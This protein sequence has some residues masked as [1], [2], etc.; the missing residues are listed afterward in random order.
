M[1]TK[2]KLSFYDKLF[3][4]NMLRTKRYFCRR[5]QEYS[6]VKQNK[7]VKTVSLEDLVLLYLW[8]YNLYPQNLKKR[9][10]PQN[11]DLVD[12]RFKE[13]KAKGVDLNQLWRKLKGI[14]PIRK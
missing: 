6:V 10:A 7:I 11:Y 14:P 13:A 1:T 2:V 9:L 4:S 5:C 3:I 12:K 8:D